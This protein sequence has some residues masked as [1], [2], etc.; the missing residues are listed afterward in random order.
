MPYKLPFVIGTESMVIEPKQS[1]EITVWYKDG[2]FSGF[3][4]K[5]QCIELYLFG[6]A[7]GA[8]LLHKE[9]VCFGTKKIVTNGVNVSEE[10]L[11]EAVILTYSVASELE[12]LGGGNYSLNIHIENPFGFGVNGNLTQELPSNIIPAGDV[13]DSIFWQLELEA[14]ERAEITLGFMSN[15]QSGSIEIPGAMLKIYDQVNDRWIEFLSNNV[16]LSL[17]LTGD[18]DSNCIVNIFDLAAVGL[19]YGQS[20]T[21]E[22]QSAD[23]TGDGA[24]N[25]F[26]LATVGLNY[27]KSC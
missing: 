9:I 1:T 22:C 14:D 15:E 10:E 26:D 4:P 17:G 23:V 21:G 11:E 18:I 16:S 8:Y 5:N 25:I 3:K 6:D 20:A 24:V 27:G 7:G 2:Y 12:E 13:N 19:C